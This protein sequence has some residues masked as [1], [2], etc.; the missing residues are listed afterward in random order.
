MSY[1]SVFSRKVS[2]SFLVCLSTALV[3]LLPAILRAAEGGAGLSATGKVDD[4]I[5]PETRSYLQMQEQL[6]A[7]QMAVDRNRKE[8]T[9]TA[10]QTAE[11]VASGMKA[12]TELSARMKALEETLNNQKSGEWQA[13]QSSNRTMLIVAGVFASFGFIALLMLG[14][15][16]WR[17]INRLAEISAIL[18]RQPGLALGLQRPRAALTAGDSMVSAPSPQ[19]SADSDL[20]QT[21]ARLEKRIKELELEQSTPSVSNNPENPEVE[22]LDGPEPHRDSNGAHIMANGNGAPE[23]AVTTRSAESEQVAM[24][25]TKGQSLLDVENAEEALECFERALALEPKNPDALVKKGAALEKMRKLIEAI[26]C[27]GTFAFIAVAKSTPVILG[28][29]KSVITS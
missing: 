20:L 4:A 22:L 16:Q 10:I 15:F 6:H 9:E 1:N 27:Y 11:V 3:L 5:S 19:P 17:T 13:M 2:R 25:L 7:T 28:M 12:T 8:S 18:P 14:Y 26:E 29:A 23:P 21:L 24:L